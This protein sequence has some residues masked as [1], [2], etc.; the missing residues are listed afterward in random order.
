MR[1]PRRDPAAYHGVVSPLGNFVH[2][3]GAARQLLIRAHQ[4]GSL[5]E[6]MVL[7]VS[8]ID[9][10][11]RI[12]LVLN[13]QLAGD[14]QGDIDAYVQQVPGGAKFT[15]REIYTEAYLSGLIDD[16]LKAEITDLYE[17][18]NAIIHRFF[19]TDLTYG[20]LGPLLDRYE[21]LYEQ[22]AAIVERL[23]L[24]QV[25]EGKGMTV[26]GPQ[27]DRQEVDEAVTAK[28]GFQPRAYVGDTPAPPSVPR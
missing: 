15:E 14:P 11:L 21:I 18:R 27:A 13:K 22:C 25:Q 12:A 6:A 23:E 9:G 3:F 5:I 4:T 26:E 17:Q 7:Y 1:R 28:L 10:F 2:S 16:G 20:N 19:L 24:R 8:V